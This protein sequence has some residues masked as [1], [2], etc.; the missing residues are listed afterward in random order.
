MLMA[1]RVE[2][3]GKSEGRPVMGWIGVEPQGD[4]TPRESGQTSIRSFLTKEFDQPFQEEKQ[5]TEQ[6]HRLGAS[7]HESA[8][9]HG[10][11][12]ARC[13]RGVR[14]LQARIVKATPC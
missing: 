10:I 8:T 5:M 1:V 4:I 6:Q 7:S 14:R 9:W 2:E 3:C 11:D 13:H 12:W